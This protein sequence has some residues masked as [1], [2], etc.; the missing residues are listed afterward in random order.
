MKTLFAVL[1]V[2]IGMSFTLF[3]HG[4]S[5]YDQDNPIK[6]SGEITES[7]YENPHGYATVKSEEGKT[8]NVV[9]APASRMQSR[10]LQADMIKP[11]TTATVEGYP[12]REKEEEMRA[13]R[14]TI[15]NKTFELR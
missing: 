15:N 14:I 11:G 5:N 3:H 9:L 7:T 13:E 8:W 1:C 6:F 2:L 4:W 10:G 12:H